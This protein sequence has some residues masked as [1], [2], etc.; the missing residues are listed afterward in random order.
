MLWISWSSIL[1]LLAL[2]CLL[3]AWLIE[4]K[5]AFVH[6]TVATCCILIYVAAYIDQNDISVDNIYVKAA[7]HIDFDHLDRL[8]E[9]NATM[10]LFSVAALWYEPI[11]RLLRLFGRLLLTMVP[12]RLLRRAS[13]T[14]WKPVPELIN[15]LGVDVP[16]APD[17]VLSGIGL[18]KATVSWARPHPSKPVHKFLIQ[19]NGVVGKQTCEGQWL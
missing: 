18:D 12:C 11:R 19:V 8:C 6:V 5:S 16:D 9:E 15:I 10:V 1:P 7:S 3:I 4:R 14:L 17:V 2:V 13:Q